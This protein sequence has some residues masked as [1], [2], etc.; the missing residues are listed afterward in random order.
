MITFAAI[1]ATGEVNI[2]RHRARPR[3]GPRRHRRR[4]LV[5]IPALLGYTT[6]FRA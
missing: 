3:R 5:A 1:A 6:W 2:S 4:P